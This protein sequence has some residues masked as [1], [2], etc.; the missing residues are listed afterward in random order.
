M[1]ITHHTW[2]LDEVEELVATLEAMRDLHVEFAARLNAAE[3]WIE[4][5]KKEA[6]TFKATQ[7]DAS[8]RHDDFIHDP[9]LPLPLYMPKPPPMV[10][11]P[12]VI[13]HK[14]WSDIKHKRAEPKPGMTPYD[15]GGES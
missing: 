10:D 12:N 2:T 4:Q 9:L 5:H 6:A 1:T 7:Q 14:K 3:A 15:L 13:H 8:K 11:G